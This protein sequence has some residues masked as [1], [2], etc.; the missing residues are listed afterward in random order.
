MDSST[1]KVITTTASGQLNVLMIVEEA[2][3]IDGI[4][5]TSNSPQTG[6]GNSA[7]HD[8][9][10]NSS[11][12]TIEEALLLVPDYDYWKASQ[13][14]I[15]LRESTV[16][17]TLCSDG[18]TLG[19]SNW[20]TLKAAVQEAN[21]ISAERFMKWSSYFAYVR[22]SNSRVFEDETLYYERDV[23]FTICPGAILKARRGPIYINAENV[24][25]ECE[26]CTIDVKTTHLAFGPHAK[27]ILVRGI[28][29]KGAHTSSLTFFHDGAEASFED[30]F[31]IGNSGISGKFGAV[32]DVNSTSTVNFYRC[33]IG[34]GRS[35]SASSLSIRA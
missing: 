9:S 17:P 4:P 13:P 35:G 24:V 28:T 8:A 16:H 7:F 19:F 29:F 26:G 1:G 14:A 30:C 5:P 27:N 34:Q 3:P 2:E 31:W 20:A 23:L 32:A 33:E 6:Q 25:I 22:D 12:C 21:S 10:S 11:P 15:N 18:V